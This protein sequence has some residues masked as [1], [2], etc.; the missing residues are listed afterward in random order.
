VELIE[1]NYEEK[2]DKNALDEEVYEVKKNL[3]EDAWIRL[4]SST[5][6]EIFLQNKSINQT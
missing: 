3:R 5:Q 1:A 2:T 4:L 6:P